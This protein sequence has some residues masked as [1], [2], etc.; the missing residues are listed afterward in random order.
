MSAKNL[1]VG[2]LNNNVDAGDSFGNEEDDGG[3]GDDDTQSSPNLQLIESCGH[4]SPRNF[5]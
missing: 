5:V 1:V 3:W 2:L 4:W